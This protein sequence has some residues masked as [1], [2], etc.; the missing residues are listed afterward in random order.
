[1]NELLLAGCNEDARRV[2]GDRTETPLRPGMQVEA[3]V[4]PAYVEV[5]NEGQR[6]ARHERCYGRKPGALAGSTALLQ[7][8][9]QGRWKAVHDEF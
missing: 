9:Q 6:V 2:I 3:T 8:R 1:M 7:R 5:W 4:Y